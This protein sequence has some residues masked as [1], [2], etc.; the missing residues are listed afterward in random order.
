MALSFLGILSYFCIE[1][2]YF[3]LGPAEHINERDSSKSLNSFNKVKGQESS[4]F[5]L[6]TRSID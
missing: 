5:L 4:N 6:Y 1:D 3:F 2:S